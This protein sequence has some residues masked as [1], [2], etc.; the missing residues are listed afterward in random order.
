MTQGCGIS[1]PIGDCTGGTTGAADGERDRND[2]RDEV[3]DGERDLNDAR[4]EVGDYG[5]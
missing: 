4:D 3:G 5:E 1:T 2:M